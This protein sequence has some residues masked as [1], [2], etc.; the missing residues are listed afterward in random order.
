MQA[1]SNGYAL[2]H[3]S[4]LILLWLIWF[5]RDLK[6]VVPVGLAWSLAALPLV[7]PMLKYREVHERLHLARDINEIQRFSLDISSVLSAPPSLA[8]WGGRLLSSQFETAFFPGL[9]VAATLAIAAVL[10]FRHRVPAP[11][12]PEAIAHG[13]RSRRSFVPGWSP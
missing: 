11:S 4:I 1:L 9:T 8:L 2:F 3:L 12:R 7:A 13:G 6:T 10:A 5:A